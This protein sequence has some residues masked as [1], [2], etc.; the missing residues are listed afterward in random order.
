LMI[1]YKT[2]HTT[3]KMVFIIL[4]YIYTSPWFHVETGL[5]KASQTSA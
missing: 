2:N 3:Y 4:I 1:I 5:S